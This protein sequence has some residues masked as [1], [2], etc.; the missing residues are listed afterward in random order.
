MFFSP[1]QTC[2]FSLIKHVYTAYLKLKYSDTS[3]SF[4]VNYIQS[5]ALFE[6]LPTPLTNVLSNAVNIFVFSQTWKQKFE[7]IRR[8]KHIFREQ[9]ERSH[10]LRQVLVSLN[11]YRA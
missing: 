3:K 5:H 9:Q 4:D 1:L 2:R 8:E 10:L 6:L 11:P 7:M